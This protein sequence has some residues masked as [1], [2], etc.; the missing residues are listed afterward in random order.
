M[1]TE[2]P[3]STGEAPVHPE[4]HDDDFWITDPERFDFDL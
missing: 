2:M 1:S 3:S 4:P